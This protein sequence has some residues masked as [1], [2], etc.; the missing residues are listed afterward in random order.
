MGDGLA[1][2]SRRSGGGVRRLGGP[3][4]R[5]SDR[6]GVGE[7]GGRPGKRTSTTPG[8]R[9]TSLRLLA[10]TRSSVTWPP[11]PHRPSIVKFFSSPQANTSVWRGLEETRRRMPDSLKRRSGCA[12]C[13]ASDLPS[14]SHGTPVA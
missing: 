4:G 5:G 9:G 1:F 7:G 13:P 14:T 8:L 12:S 6:G 2:R 3:P 11:A 10:T